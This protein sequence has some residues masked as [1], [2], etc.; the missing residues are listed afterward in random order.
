MRWGRLFSVEVAV[1]DLIT[2]TNTVGQANGNT[3]TPAPDAP[4]PTQHFEDFERYA[5]GQE[6][7]FFAQA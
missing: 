6:A 2:L 3:T 1:D 4:F 5:V 7:D